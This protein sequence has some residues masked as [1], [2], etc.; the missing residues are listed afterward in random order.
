MPKVCECLVYLLTC[1]RARSK[2][3]AAL[4]K[5]VFVMSSY[6]SAIVSFQEDVSELCVLSLSVTLNSHMPLG[7]RMKPHTH[8]GLTVQPHVCHNIRVKLYRQWV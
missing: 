5:C 3:S 1:K 4:L 7:L 8:L 2:S 6:V